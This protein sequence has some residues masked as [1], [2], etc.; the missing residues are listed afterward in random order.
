MISNGSNIEKEV[1]EQNQIQEQQSFDFD[2]AL[3]S[4]E[5]A[6]GSLVLRSATQN[7]VPGPTKVIRAS[8]KSLFATILSN[9]KNPIK[10]IPA[11]VLVVVWLTISILQASGINPLPVKILSFLTFA[12]AGLHGGFIGA[13]GGIIGKG[14][15]A[16]AVVIII[17]LFKKKNKCEK[18]SLKETIHGSFGFSLN[19][20]F[21][22]L[23]GIGVAMLFYLFI[24]GGATKRAFM[25]GMAV[26]LLAALSALNGGFIPNIINAFTSKGKTKAS[27]A[28][29]GFTRGLALGFII[30]AFVGLIGIN[31]IL[32]ITGLVLV[33]VGIVFMV[34][35]K[36]GV[37]KLGK[38]D[39]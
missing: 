37:V 10:L 26:M 13:I 7:V 36:T 31:L 17:S 38:E 39:K 27:E 1:D 33:V 15:F 4:G 11:I 6:L 23:V 22:F 30:S 34:L 28:G 18:R 20:L 25:G 16:C 32:I 5:A 12:E 14:L 21:V 2:A 8:F 35:Q 29:V 24:S 19:T 3:A 9:F